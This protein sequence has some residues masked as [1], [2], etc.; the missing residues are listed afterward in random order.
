[1]AKMVWDNYQAKLDAALTRALAV[2]LKGR[3][4]RKKGG[5][6]GKYEPFVLKCDS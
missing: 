4:E 2:T 6:E 5:K 1:M 3:D